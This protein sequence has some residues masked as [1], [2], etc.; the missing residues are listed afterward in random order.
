MKIESTKL[1]ICPVRYGLTMGGPITLNV[2]NLDHQ[3]VV[4]DYE[5]G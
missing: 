5:C 4:G 3:E 1:E 2:T